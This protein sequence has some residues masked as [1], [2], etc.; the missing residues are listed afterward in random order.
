[1]TTLLRFALT[2]ALAGGP[3]PLPPNVR[4]ATPA[5]TDGWQSTRTYQAFPQPNLVPWPRSITAESGYT[6]LP[7]T[8]AII[9]VTDAALPAATLL[10]ADLAVLTAGALN[11]TVG[12]NRARARAPPITITLGINPVQPGYSTLEVDHTGAVLSG[13]SHEALVAAATTLLQA[14]EFSGDRDSVTPTKYNCTT[15]PAWRLPLL[16]IA[17]GPEFGYRGLLV[18]AARS[19]VH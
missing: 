13:R 9:A 6:A 19:H 17:D 15:R 5:E 12:P 11:L 16:T 2:A 10:A 8:T 1:M 3:S 4:C 14:L 7:I 18:D